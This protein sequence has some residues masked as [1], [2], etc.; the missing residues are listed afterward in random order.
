MP[1]IKLTKIH[2]HIITQ[3]THIVYFVDQTLV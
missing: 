3:T 1:E 2:L